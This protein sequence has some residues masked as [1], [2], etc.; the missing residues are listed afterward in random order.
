[1]VETGFGVTEGS[2]SQLKKGDSVQ[3]TAE[4]AAKNAGALF[5]SAL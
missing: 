3:V 5:I 2:K 1:V 4:T